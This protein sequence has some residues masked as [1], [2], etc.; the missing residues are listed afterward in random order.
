M[1][2]L[3]YRAAGMLASILGGIVAGA[4]FKKAWK[5]TAGED[6]APAATDAQ[7]GWREVLLAATLQGAI[8]GAVKAAIDR[9]TAEG[10]RKLTGVWPGENAE[11]ADHR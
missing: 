6:E 8:F 9:G 10:T 11:A 4:I 3:L 5:I 1:K 2:K 7:R